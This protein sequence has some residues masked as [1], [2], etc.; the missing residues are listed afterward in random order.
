MPFIPMPIHFMNSQSSIEPSRPARP[1]SAAGLFFVEMKES[2]RRFVTMP[3]PGVFVCF[4]S[5]RSAAARLAL[6]AP[7][8]PLLQP[9][10]FMM[11]VVLPL[12]I[13]VTSTV[14]MRYKCANDASALVTAVWHAAG[15]NE[16]F[17]VRFELKNCSAEREV[18]QQERPKWHNKKGGRARQKS[19]TSKMPRCA[20]AYRYPSVSRISGPKLTSLLK[21]LSRSHLVHIIGASRT[22]PFPGNNGLQ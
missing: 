14:C 11:L 22:P 12:F 13:V 3:L 17:A 21:D 20:I 18:A 10:L 2:E 9:L 1:K 7:S 16:W 4:C 6:E 19:S 8:P 5:L 15:E